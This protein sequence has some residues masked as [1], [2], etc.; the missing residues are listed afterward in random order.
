[1][2]SLFCD[3]ESFFKCLWSLG[4]SRLY[5]PWAGLKCARAGLFLVVRSLR[6][7]VVLLKSRLCWN[8]QTLFLNSYRWVF[9]EDSICVLLFFVSWE[10]TIGPYCLKVGAPYISKGYGAL[11]VQL[12][13][14]N[15]K[16]S[17]P[18]C[19]QLSF[20]RKSLISLILATGDQ[21]W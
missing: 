15:K 16:K 18:N 14:I 13:W 19:A 17:S 10:V 3:R 9:S 12:Y 6:V 4:F 7:F 21:H 5:F 11:T 20:Q 2:S 1:M 8:P